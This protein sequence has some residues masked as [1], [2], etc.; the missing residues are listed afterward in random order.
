M[1]GRPFE[2]A[3]ANWNGAGVV[4]RCVESVLTALD[5]AGVAAGVTVIDDASEDGSA[6]AVATRFPSVRLLRLQEN[7]GYGAAV[8]RAMREIAAPW[9]FLLNNDLAVSSDYIARLLAARDSVDRE[10]LF[11]I[12]AMTTAWG[13]EAPNHGG[14]RAVWRRG[15][16][17]QEGFLCDERAPTDFVQAGACLID[18]EKF[19]ALGGFD[20]IFAPGYW[21]D[22][23]VCYQARRRGWLNYYEPSAR[24]AHWGKRSMKARYGE[25][26]VAI[27]L[28]RNHLLF[29]W[30]NLTDPALLARHFAGLG[31]LALR[32]PSPADRDGD[33]WG[34]ASIEALGLLPAALRARARRPRGADVSDREILGLTDR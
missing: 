29:N 20:P 13:G 32:G 26:R 9:V 31:G 6:D 28:K 25:R 22:Y 3:I 19:L 18:R 10:R 21:E 4:E 11:A 34:R 5:V 15:M 12:G 1:S 7:V 2:V 27:A 33:L 17:A 16:I 30:L 24:A 23:D 8:N 14:M